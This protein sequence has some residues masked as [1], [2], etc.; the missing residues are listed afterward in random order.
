MNKKTILLAFFVLL[1]FAAVFASEPKPLDKASARQKIRPELLQV[2]DE[3][4]A[5]PLGT[6][7]VREIGGAPLA[8][9][10]LEKAVRVSDGKVKV[11]LSIEN[12]N[13][14]NTVAGRVKA[15]GGTLKGKF[16]AGKTIVAEL[17]LAKIEEI[18]A[19]SAVIQVWPDFE[20]TALEEPWEQINA[21]YAWDL[22]LKG[23]GIKV[24]VLDTGIDGTHPALQGKVVAAE[25][26]STS[27]TEAD[28]F[29]HGTHVAGIIAGSGVV[30]GVAPEAM[31]LNG[32]VLNDSG[33]GTASSVI[34]GINWAIEQGAGVINLSLGA[35]IAETDTPLNQAVRDAIAHGVVVVAAAGNCGSSCSGSSCSGFV[36]VT[37]PGNTAEAITVGAV[38]FGN[39][40]ACFSGSSVIGSEIKP[41]LTAPGVGIVSSVPGGTEAKSGTS[42][43]APFASGAA[44]LLLQQHAGYSPQEV[45]GLLE[46]TALDL[47]VEG[48]D[49]VY[50]WGLLDL[51]GMDSNVDLSPDQNAWEPPDDNRGV[52]VNFA[53]SEFTFS[54]PGTINKKTTGNFSVW[55]AG[56]AEQSVEG[57]SLD[58]VDTIVEFIVLNEF[59]DVVD[60][61][62][63]GPKEYH[64]DSMLSFD[65]GWMPERTGDFTVR[66]TVFRE[67]VA[68]SG[69]APADVRAATAEKSVK[70]TVPGDMLQINSLAVP[71]RIEQG[72]S[73]A[74]SLNVTNN[75]Y[76]DES[77]IA[78]IRFADEE[79]N[80]F[81]VVASQAMQ[82]PIGQTTE[83]NLNALVD[84]PD[85][86]YAVTGILYFEDRNVSSE[87]QATVFFPANCQAQ[88][89]IIPASIEAGGNLTGTIEFANITDLDAQ[90][91]FF[92]SV[93]D[94]NEAVGQIFFDGN[95]VEAGTARQYPFNWKADATPRPYTLRFDVQYNGNST[96][97]E[98][99]F[100]VVDTTPPAIIA[101]N[102][103]GDVV[104]NQ[105]NP[106]QVIAS[107][108]T[109]VAQ[110]KVEVQMI[111]GSNY[112]LEL[113]QTG[114][115]RN[116]E[117]STAFAETGET[118]RYLLHPVV[119]DG[120]GNQA[121]GPIFEF[122]VREMPAQCDGKNILLV[123]G[124][125]GFTLDQNGFQ[126]MEELEQERECTQLWKK[127]LHGAP[128]LSYLQKFDA[129][130]WATGNRFGESVDA[131]DSQL[132]VGYAN[133]GGRILLSGSD[134]ASEHVADELMR[135]VAHA[136]WET[137]PAGDA[138]GTAIEF[139]KS[140]FMSSTPPVGFD[141][142][143]APFF[144]TLTGVE[145]GEPLGYIGDRVVM[146]YSHSL[147]TNSKTVF[148]AVALSALEEIAREQFVGKVLDWLF[149]TSTPGG[150]LH[151][152]EMPAYEKEQPYY[153]GA[154]AA[155]MILDYVRLAAG[156]PDLNQDE[157]YS[158]GLLFKL[159]EN[160]GI[161]ELDADAM[162]AVLGHFDP[163]DL[164][165]SNSF[166][167]YDSLEDGNPYQGYN[168]TVDTHDNVTEYMREIAHWMAW[169]VPQEAWWVQ[170]VELVAEPNTPAALPIYGDYNHWVVLNGFAAS[171]NPV[172]DP[173]GDPWQT[174]DITMFGFWLTDPAAGGIG[175]HVY[176]TAADANAVYFRPMSTSDLY[177]GKYL[178][179]AEPPAIPPEGLPEGMETESRAKTEIAQPVSDLGNL[180]F[181]G[182]ETKA[183]GAEAEPLMTA[184]GSDLTGTGVG[185]EGWRD[186]VDRHLLADAE[187]VAAFDSALAGEPVLV[188]RLDNNSEYYLIPFNKI[189]ERWQHLL[190]RWP[191]LLQWLTRYRPSTTGVIM[192]DAGDGHFRQ[193]SWTEEP[194]NY[195][196]VTES[197]AI[198]LARRASWEQN[199]KWPNARDTKALLS[200]QPGRHSASPFNPY[201]VVELG[202]E[203]WVVTQEGKAEKIA[204]QEPEI[205]LLEPADKEEIIEQTAFKWE[206]TG[207]SYYR[208]YV[209]QDAEFSAG[210]Y[211]AIGGAIR[212]NELPISRYFMQ[213]L[214]LETRDED[215]ILHWKVVGY[216][217]AEKTESSVQSFTIK[218][219]ES[220][221]LQCLE[222]PVNKNYAFSWSR[223]EYS[224]FYLQLGYDKEFAR[225]TYTQ[226]T[227]KTS[228][229]NQRSHCKSIIQRNRREV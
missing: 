46:Q 104:Q 137:E 19:D 130:I 67:G 179:V 148:S 76:L 219:P 198:Y 20:V 165:V 45:R 143:M 39:T 71:G 33:S 84:L 214:S 43:S 6:G 16:A 199:K 177:S 115:D 69:V 80:I 205:K 150:I 97:I 124:D 135:Q 17:P 98:E 56:A 151:L 27:G 180:E 207:F 188:K 136:S 30:Q 204:D 221:K 181:V 70:V 201:W 15:K 178:Q 111:G 128:T 51:S 127:S 59:G 114:F 162:D 48:E 36:G 54:G 154:A 53:E 102:F 166:D 2:I 171:G 66:A 227:A 125:T 32:K 122:A 193:A 174:A 29:G 186:I 113:A 218:Q 13:K 78:E 224:A 220:P 95:T 34:A 60:R 152:T 169:P 213:L 190:E 90:P 31:L 126:W 72:T 175:K 3:A 192:L 96:Q 208:L 24:A 129:V 61:H 47:G 149:E 168:Y 92:G 83:I 94:G 107:D 106:I 23:K 77:V 118:G 81:K 91:L 167:M 159:P 225:G 11:L 108:E 210:K 9:A 153:S 62:F 172:P 139:A 170:P 229:Q 157:L 89:L 194:V 5:T 183:G 101:V 63:E 40:A 163:Y 228:P 147:D 103:S 44:A 38:D 184:M 49:A 142:N 182:A 35:P 217:G 191:G 140:S 223:G 65:Y 50:G 141:G 7:V 132:L 68:S 226:I 110:V 105:F 4:K 209:S 99:G 28:V 55:H 133:A 215:K 160:A 117:W 200:W 58:T 138:N 121:P 21:D 196:P 158:Y 197:Q 123:A 116:S 1:L 12:K 212:A 100:N 75:G 14:L 74:F 93:L 211:L 109:G 18:A 173:Y 203:T 86:N 134:I 155:E 26:F 146:T 120:Y 164:I 8:E 57:Q 202:R 64:P 216:N 119:T 52:D 195:L 42:M 85:A 73:A 37:M 82:V 10:P 79:K 112:L 87:Q 206:G 185:K 187:A 145:T 25:N 41:D 22:G 131:N 222:Q 156:Q 161:L 189:E 88:N 144:D 176:V